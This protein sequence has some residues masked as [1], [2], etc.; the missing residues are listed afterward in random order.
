MINQGFK[1]HVDI[2]LCIDATNSMS[3]VIDQVKNRALRFYED[4]TEAMGAK[5][6]VVDVLRLKVIAF[7][8]FY[9]DGDKALNESPFYPL[10]QAQADFASFVGTLRAS[11]GGD[12]PENGLEAL[13][14]A[15]Q[16]DWT[17]SGDKRRHVIVM[18]TDTSAHELEKNAGDKPS[19]YPMGMPA[20]FD[21]L[22]DMWEG[23]SHT[24]LSAKRLVIFAP[25]A[26]AWT[27]IANNWSNNLHYSSQAGAGL[28]DVDYKE[29]IDVVAG[30]V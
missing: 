17:K 13:A 29:I 1:Y 30:S 16:T 7:R 6:K 20:N 2:V 21:E 4:L 8:D 11:G 12:L 3:P 14:L 25:D 22:T 9:A 18:W 24:E 28:A 27:D 23:Q 15:I 26:Y 19:N 10:P 5:D